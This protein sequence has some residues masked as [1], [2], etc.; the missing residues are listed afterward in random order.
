MQKKQKNVF[1][2]TEIVL[3][4]TGSIAAFKACEIASLLRK[5]GARISVIMTENAKQFITPLSL[6]YISGGGVYLDM[7]ATDS[8]MWSDTHIGLSARARL[9]VVAPASADFIARAAGGRA[10]DLLTSTLL[11]TK[12]PVV[13]VPAMNTGMYTHPITQKN[14]E[15]LKR[16]GY[17]ILGP[18]EGSLACGDE[19]AGRMVEPEEIIRYLSELL[20]GVLHLKGKMGTVPK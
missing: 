11:T 10:S 6:Q 5:L 12:K 2:N 1:K 3:G 19:G 7:F 8:D 20:T 18:V 4:V 17:H 14:I 13:V 15:A 9:I 16:A